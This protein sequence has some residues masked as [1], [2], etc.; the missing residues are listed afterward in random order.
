MLIFVNIFAP[1]N[2][3]EI[4]MAIGYG[5]SGKIRGKLGSSVYRIQSGKQVISEYNPE[6]TGTKSQG[7]IEMRAKMAMA[8]NVSRCF[9]SDLLVGLSRSRAAARQTLV[10][11]IVKNAI[12]V[13]DTDNQIW[14]QFDATKLELS[15]GTFIPADETAVRMSG[16]TKKIVGVTALL[17]PNFGENDVLFVILPKVAI[18]GEFKQAIGRMSEPRQA[19]TP[20]TASIQVSE[21]ENY[22]TTIF[23][24]YAI[25]IIPNALGRRAEYSELL[26]ADNSALFSTIAYLYNTRQVNFGKTIY[27]GSVASQD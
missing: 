10:G 13:P 2:Q 14:A 8:N 18:T 16:I 26:T 17:P 6:K 22:P 25:P 15:K 5:L 9:P 12:I 19:G 27:C 3:N 7:Q 1:G 23:H 24:A 20:A 4:T 21:V 11:S